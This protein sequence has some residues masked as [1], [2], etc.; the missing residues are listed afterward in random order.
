MDTVT[1]VIMYDN[2]GSIL[3]EK[4]KSRCTARIDSL[5]L[6]W[7]N[8]FSASRPGSEVYVVNNRTSDT[9]TVSDEFYDM[10]STAVA[11]G[12]SLDGLFDITVIPLK[13]FWK[14]SAKESRDPDPA[15]DSVKT[16]VD[17]LLKFVDYRAVTLLGDNQIAFR[18][19]DISIDLGGIAK[20]RVIRELQIMLKK[21]GLK[22]FLI[23]AGGDILVQGKK[24]TGELFKV[25]VRDPR[26][27]DLA[28]VF[29]LKDGAVVTSGDYER[30]RIAGSG[31]RVHHLFDPRTGYPAMLNSSLTVVGEDPVVVD[32]LSTALFTKP[33]DE[34]LNYINS[35]P[36]FECMI[37][38]VDQKIYYS[39]G[40]KNEMNKKRSDK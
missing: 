28:A 34:I 6:E 13:E 40:F 33:A 1:D 36:E 4:K 25:G 37:V 24:S 39:T 20:G 35:R 7:E 29:S 26:S 11:Y 8:R 22:N 16:V 32:I 38:T 18:N 23:S 21:N 15:V 27:E 10:V 31:E 3:G 17:S 9:V 14:P 5:L 30:F 19:R 2:F 12:D